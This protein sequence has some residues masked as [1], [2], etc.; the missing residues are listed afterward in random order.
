M[1]EEHINRLERRIGH[2]ERELATHGTQLVRN[3]EAI[4]YMKAASDERLAYIREQ[5][6]D[7][8]KRDEAII[9]TLE[10]KGENNKWLF[11]VILSIVF[12]LFVAINYAY[13]EPIVDTINTL[14]R[15]LLDVE[16][17]L[18]RAP[19]HDTPE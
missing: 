9:S 14:E 13:V 1:G 16:K 10:G 18:N 3:S 11:N 6:E 19:F 8:R 17:N 5:F 2:V 7:A 12:A 4:D 15:R